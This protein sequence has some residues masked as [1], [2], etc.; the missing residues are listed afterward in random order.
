MSPSPVLVLI[1]L[2]RLFLIRNLLEVG[3]QLFAVRIDEQLHVVPR[4]TQPGVHQRHA[5]PH[6]RIRFRDPVNNFGQTFA[7]NNSVSPDSPNT[8]S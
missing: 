8:P 7:K 5:F 3:D 2:R 4:I 1:N 6:R